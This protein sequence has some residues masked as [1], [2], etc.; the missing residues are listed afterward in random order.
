MTEPANDDLSPG[1][2]HLIPI[3]EVADHDEDCWCEP[4]YQGETPDGCHVYL[5]FSKTV[6]TLQ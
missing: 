2:F 1:E 3:N 6:R 4:D 5:H